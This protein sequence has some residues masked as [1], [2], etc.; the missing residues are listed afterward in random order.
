[1]G[2]SPTREVGSVRKEGMLSKRVSGQAIN[3]QTRYVRLT[4]ENIYTRLDRNNMLSLHTIDLLSISHTRRVLGQQPNK[5]LNRRF[6][7]AAVDLPAPTVES[8][9]L[10]HAGAV[11]G[12]NRLQWENAFEIYVES[13]GMTYYYKAANDKEC[14]EWVAAITDAMQYAQE[15]HRQSLNI[16][17]AERTRVAVRTVYE[18]PL[19]QGFVS[20][21]LLA[22]FVMSII[23]GEL[24]AQEAQTL[25]ET[26]DLVDMVFTFIY[27]G[28]LLI[29][30]YCTPW[31][32]FFSNGWCVFDL[33]IVAVSLFDNLYLLAAG[34]DG[35]GLS[36]IRLLR[37]LRIVRI[38][39]RLSSLVGGGTSCLLAQ[40]HNH[41]AAVPPRD[42]V[43]RSDTW[44]CGL[45]TLRSKRS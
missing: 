15:V 12:V 29:C 1:L 38:F 4:D 22:N 30:M 31:R 25:M 44:S 39:K 13:K 43:T 2:N 9:A 34:G 5:S 33:I 8:D 19:T 17:A 28:E 3:W 26:L 10:S 7:I 20:T 36:V 40:P 18:H 45:A 35:S 23:Q 42:A 16:G 24:A 21:L 37:I 11:N 14:D 27:T 6:S 41:S 32:E